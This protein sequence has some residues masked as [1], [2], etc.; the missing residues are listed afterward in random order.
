MTNAPAA[1]EILRITKTFISY[2]FK[3]DKRALCRQCHWTETGFFIL[4]S[5]KQS[6]AFEY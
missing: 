3:S 6:R 2:N 5:A 4:I 1:M